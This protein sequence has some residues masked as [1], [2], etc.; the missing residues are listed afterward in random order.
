MFKRILFV[1]EPHLAATT[2]VQTGAALATACH[3]EIVFCSGLPRYPAAAM[4]LP[5]METS[6]QWVA[7]ADARERTDRLL[8]QA[9]AVVEGL[10]VPSRTAV[11]SGDDPVHCI[12]QTAQANHCDLILV[13]KEDSNAVVRLLT[14]NVVPS[15]I[16]ASPVPVLVCAAA[17][18]STPADAG[19]SMHRILVLLDEDGRSQKALTQALALA[20]ACGSE[21]LF[22]HVVPP[23]VVPVLEMSSFATG[24]GEQLAAAIHDRSQRLLD[25]AQAVARTAGLQAN[26]LSLAAA[27]THKDIAR[28]VVEKACDLVVVSHGGHNAVMRLLTGSLIPGL[29]TVASVPLLVCREGA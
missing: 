26:G 8:V 17:S 15:L 10:G 25:S 21:L 19:K 3:A 14:G 16:T 13:A 29:I 27:T 24:P 4:D 2:A 18:S 20:Q 23:E 7:L 1:V 28:L 11:T 5:D 12:L 9:K 6:A 22:A